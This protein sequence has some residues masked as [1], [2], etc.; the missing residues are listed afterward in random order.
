MAQNYVL[1]ER[2]ELNASAASVTFSNIPQSGYTDLKIVM[3]IRGD[4]TNNYG[5][6]LFN[7]NS[8]GYTR[9]ILYGNG[10]NVFSTG[11]TGYESLSI[12]PSDAT[13]ST[14]ANYEM[15]IP[16]YTSSNSKSFS[17][18][19]VGEN[20]GTTAQAIFHAGIWAN[21]SAISSIV[22]Q[23]TGNFVQYSTFSLY[24]LAAV[25]TTPAIAPKASGGNITTDG[26]YWYHT[27]LASGTF[28]PQLNITCDTLVVAGGGS[29][30][31]T[32][33]GGGGGAGGL[34]GLS[35]QS[36]TNNTAYTV[37]IGAGGVCA[38]TNNIGSNGNN[39]SLVGTGLTINASGGGG[40]GFVSQST[41]NPQYAGLSGGSGGGGQGSSLSGSAG[42]SGNAGSYSPVEGY[43][44]GYGSNNQPPYYGSGGGGGA[45]GIGG[46]GTSGG[47]GAGGV[48]SSAYSSWGA[49]TA[50][51]QNVSSTY[52]YAG[53]G[54]GSAYSANGGAGGNGG[55]GAG[56]IG[57]GS[58]GTANTGGGGGGSE[59]NAGFVAGGQGGSGIVII[60]YS[61]A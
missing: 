36:L 59:R 3:S 40:G 26:T 11:P 31:S 23:P 49:A 2:I 44:G 16:N 53:G 32:Y 22:I 14:F 43:A 19:A 1:L 25:G 9:K 30:G 18:D 29:G 38:G 28:T 15:Y 35:A 34:R 7:N 58:A 51:G 57:Q 61:V 12:N 6:V 33:D 27:F 48:G 8:S 37:T 56:S 17:V 4:N 39:S 13:A 21:S 52:Y 60:R 46:T 50:T 24:A 42:G 54:G 10:S 20:N 55:G 47:G 45:G 5:S 41:G